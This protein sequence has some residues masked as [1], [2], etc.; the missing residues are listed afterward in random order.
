M[1]LGT[2]YFLRQEKVEEYSA[3]VLIACPEPAFKPSFFKE[4]KLTLLSIE[5]I[6]WSDE[7]K[8]QKFENYS[9]MLPVYKQ[10]SY[11]LGLDWEIAMLEF[12]YNK[13]ILVKNGLAFLPIGN[14]NRFWSWS[15]LAA[16]PTMIN[17]T[18]Q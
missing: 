14:P 1:I 17:S 5:K 11:Q 15:I 13:N 10:M 2:V 16:C 4:N 8:R 12:R 18:M 9:S 6:F 7:Q 3:P